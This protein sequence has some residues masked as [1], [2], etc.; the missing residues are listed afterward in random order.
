MRK[1]KSYNP[2]KMWGSWVGTGIG[3][4]YGIFVPVCLN[5][6]QDLGYIVVCRSGLF[7]YPIFS[8]MIIGLVAGYGIHSL[9]RRNKK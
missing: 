7:F 3:A 9:I 1:K 6:S 2:F 4:I 5:N 8:W